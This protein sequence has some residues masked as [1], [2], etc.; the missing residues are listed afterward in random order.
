MGTINNLPDSAGYRTD[1]C[2]SK[3]VPTLFNCNTGAAS[4]I[5]QWVLDRNNILYA[6][7]THAA[8]K[9]HSLAEK[10]TTKKSKINYPVLKMTDA[11][12]YGTESII[13][14]WEKRCLPQDRLLPADGEQLDKVL[15][16]Y[17]QFTDDFF[18]GMVEKYMYNMMLTSKKLAGKVLKQNISFSE[19]GFFSLRF[20]GIKKVLAL[21]YE[22]QEND[23]D[24]C[25]AEIRKVFD[26][27]SQLLADGR[28]YLTGDQFTLADLAFAAIAAPM[29]LPEEYGGALPRINEVPDAYR[30]HITELR[31][32]PAGQFVFMLYQA[33]RPSMIP[34]SEI[35]K[36]PGFIKKAIGK[37]I[38]KLKK[39]Q[40]KTFY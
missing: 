27:V 36:E 20:S 11:F 25:M 6:N 34:Q 19:K 17:Y 5:A 13:M 33:C 15:E 23:T 18:A 10:L 31:A 30:V 7:E 3:S 38:I 8:W 28:K 9:T 39:K 1:F 40:Y 24:E 29:I 21:N 37:L 14:F 16:L 4:E 2:Y 26:K 12:I 35:P 22:L 32:T